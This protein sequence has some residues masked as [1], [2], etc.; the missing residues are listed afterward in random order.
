MQ[1]PMFLFACILLFTI[2]LSAFDPPI[3]T[4][5][6]LTAR[7]DGPTE[8]QSIDKPFNVSVVLQND[9]DEPI[10]G[11]VKIGL[12]DE[13]KAEPQHSS[14][15]IEAKSK[16]TLEFK[17]IPSKET[18]NA[19]YP[20]HAFIDFHYKE[21]SFQAHPIL[22]L[23]TNIP[24]P[25]KPKIDIPWKPFEVHPNS[26]IALWRLP[27]YRAVLR[28]FGEKPE[29]QPVGL[30]GVDPRTKASWSIGDRVL[31]GDIRET[32]AMH[33]PWFNNQVGTIFLE[34]PLKLPKANKIILRFANAIRDNTAEEPPSDGVTFRVRVVPFTAKD[35]EEGEIVYE[36]HT[37]AKVWAEGEA[38]LSKFAG[39]TIRIQLESHPGPKNDTTCDQSYWAEPTLLVGVPP[40]KPVFPPSLTAP[41]RKIGNIQIDGSNYEVR[42]WEG[43]RG[44]LD[45]T[46]G[47]INDSKILLFNG[48]K[49]K[50][51]GDDLS[52][53]RSTCSL[54]SVKKEEKDGH[55][56]Y[57]HNFTSWLGD[58][59][60]LSDIW[61]ENGALR[62]KFVLNNVPPSRPWIVAY[63]EDVSLGEWNEEA[64]RVYAGDGNILVAPEAFNLWFDGHQLSTSFV[65][66]DF[67]NGISLVEGVDSPPSY[68]EFTP[69]AHIYTLHTP[70][71]QTIS[72]IPAKSSWEAAKVWRNINGLKPAGG[73]P[74]LAGRFVFDLW[75]GTYKGTAEALERAFRYGLTDS[76]VVW[77]NWQRWG[78]DYR[79]PDIF[80]PNPQFGTLDE[81]LQLV[82]TCKRY[83]VLFAPHDNYIDF[84]PDAE[85]FSYKRIAFNRDRTPVPAWFN[86]GRKAQSYRWRADQLMP[87]LRR[88]L[89]L[90]KESFAPT[91][92]F[93]DV[94]SSICPYDYW[95]DE[96]K[97]FTRIYTRDVWRN[98]FAWIR[99]FLGDNAPQISE[100]GHDQLIG[101][102][103][104]GQTNHLRVDIPPPGY[105]S[106]A[107]W[108]IR[109][110]DAERI[111]W[112]DTAHHSKFVLH[113]AGYESR[114]ASGQDTRLHGIYSDDYIATEVLTGH[115][116]M[117][118]APFGRDVVRKYYLLHD[119]ARALALKDIENVEFYQGD[120]HKQVVKWNN[121]GLVWV[122][123]GKE[124]WTIEGHILPQYGVYARI[125]SDAGLVE[126]S[127]ERKD[128]VIVEWSRSPS[129]IYVN[130]RPVVS[131]RLPVKVSVSSLKYK[132]NRE[133]E[134]ELRWEASRPLPKEMMVF[135]HF[136][137]KS[138]EIIF[139]ADHTPTIP[140]TQWQGIINTKGKFTIPDK[141]KSGDEFEI[142]VGLWSPSSGE[143]ALLEGYDDGTARIR[144]G[145]LQLEGQGSD[146]T[147]ISFQPLEEK[148]DPVL[149]RMNP[150]G[151]MIDFGGIITN[152][153]FKLTKE[154][155]GLHLIPLPNSP[156]YE[157]RIYWSSLPWQVS[158][159]QIVEEIS[160]NGEVLRSYPLKWEGNYAVLTHSP[161]TFAYI[162][163]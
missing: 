122:N 121:G 28:V 132:G 124:D 65:G 145:K 36:K 134:I 133:G 11:E 127:I 24:N 98:A 39:Q 64:I 45:S 148:E 131:E 9:G 13:W 29:V 110:Q 144:L 92:Y 103:D 108:S 113:G 2:Q 17:I 79:L 91:A 146:I 25:P 3:D 31:R 138:G 41:Y 72:L 7:I 68:L 70:H 85:G 157:A 153:A 38:D 158:Q 88:N 143:R 87:F 117:V 62:V 162:L 14:F 78:Y 19:H 47:F 83:G 74:K 40:Q 123:R 12:I 42:I 111:P 46:I 151:K 16:K 95:T 34:F 76:V 107:V 71:S 159:A 141:Y 137:D 135:V 119:F 86:E 128:G 161:G 5:G 51:L 120:I 115:P 20:I 125:P 94:W 75:G 102:L 136:V 130:A 67:A 8:V 49:V 109:C 22:I 101:W 33:P 97:F 80:P 149:A 63:I 114:Y 150:Q 53:W 21:K 84:Y 56:I 61:L 99:D 32:I 126:V 18:Y 26:A 142:R 89:H 129:T 104:G 116:A 37:L 54:K 69:Q 59:S 48:F 58:L 155:D 105:Y 160:E 15:N 50:V 154:K 27:V 43:K 90:I 140:T 93:I 77:H 147:S 66:F 6:P 35:G 82:E 10:S 1:L 44:I 100:S 60:L 81:F 118:P 139:Q 112:Y 106:W 57:T 73:V 55:L 52:D 30:S 152:G 23:K 96:G 4:A 156:E 163:K